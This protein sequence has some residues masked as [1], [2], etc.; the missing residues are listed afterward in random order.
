M[1]R[2]EGSVVM[3]STALTDEPGI[4]KVP[5][6]VSIDSPGNAPSGTRDNASATFPWNIH[7]LHVIL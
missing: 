6:A 2:T 3:E 5:I 1:W 7:N 4:V